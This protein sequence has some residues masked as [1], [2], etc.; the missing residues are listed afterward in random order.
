MKDKEFVRDLAESYANVCLID[1]NVVASVHLEDKND[2]AFWNA[3]L[4]KMFSSRDVLDNG[5]SFLNRTSDN[6]K[7]ELLLLDV[8]NMILKNIKM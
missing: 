5:C 8:K 7:K 4:Q 1:R 3:R 6:F 2:E